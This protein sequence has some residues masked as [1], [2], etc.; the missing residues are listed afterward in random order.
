MHGDRVS[1]VDCDRQQQAAAA[2]EVESTDAVSVHVPQDG[3]R[4]PT[5]RLPDVYRRLRPNLTRRH[6]PNKL[7][8]LV[9]RQTDDV[10]GVLA[11][12]ALR[13]YE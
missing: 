11:I 10:V 5:A 1:A 8:M 7:R 6:H 3:H 13:S 4:L 9:G 12:E 2:G